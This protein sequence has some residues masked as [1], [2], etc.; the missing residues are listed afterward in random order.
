[1]FWRILSHYVAGF[2]TYLPIYRLPKIETGGKNRMTE[3]KPDE[4]LN[5][6]EYTPDENLTAPAE[7]QEQTA[8]DTQNDYLNKPDAPPLETPAPDISDT[9]PTSDVPE[10]ML[11][12][13][14]N[15]AS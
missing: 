8:N 9:L 1:L 7:Q 11:L 3:T 4:I 15:W 12:S 6:A 2:N 14:E 10:K 13:S 5:G